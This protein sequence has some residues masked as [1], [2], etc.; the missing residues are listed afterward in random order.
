MEIIHDYTDRDVKY[1]FNLWSMHTI[2]CPPLGELLRDVEEYLTT[3]KFD[4]PAHIDFIRKSSGNIA[5]GSTRVPLV[6][7]IGGEK[8]V[9]KRYDNYDS[10][11]E[12]RVLRLVG[13]VC[14]PEVF[15]FGRDFYAE[16]FIDPKQSQSLDTLL[17][18][19]EMKRAVKIGGSM[20]A[21]LARLGVNYDHNHWLDEFLL[22]GGRRVILDFG[23]S[24]LYSPAEETNERMAFLKKGTRADLIR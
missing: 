7:D 12:Q 23:T 9:V 22:Y 15:H 13:G 21:R 24:R 16:E 19:G 6:V 8:A 17:T 20:H 5:H 4:G 18:A 1:L 11:R 14:A 2:S 10:A 3:K